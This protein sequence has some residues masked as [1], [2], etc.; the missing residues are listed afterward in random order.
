MKHNIKDQ[1]HKYL[2][3][4]NSSKI[5]A[6]EEVVE[7]EEE[8][9]EK[10]D[11]EQEIE[12]GDLRGLEEDERIIIVPP[13]EESTV[14]ADGEDFDDQN[15]ETDSGKSPLNPKANFLFPLVKS[16]LIRV[17]TVTKPVLTHW[18]ST[19]SDFFSL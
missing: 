1:K 19:L 4:S 6:K 2:I 17:K 3:P 14:E 9:E 15:E 12:I 13:K 5:Q 18:Y 7:P 16:F 8:K 10:I 11:F